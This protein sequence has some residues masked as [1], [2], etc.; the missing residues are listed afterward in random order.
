[1]KHQSG[2]GKGRTWQ[3]GGKPKT[4]Y[5][6]LIFFYNRS[7]LKTFTITYLFSDWL[8]SD[9]TRVL[10]HKTR[11]DAW[12]AKRH[13]FGQELDDGALCERWIRWSAAIQHVH[14][15]VWIM[16]A[17]SGDVHWIYS[18]LAQ[19]QTRAGVLIG[20]SGRGGWDQLWS[21]DVVWTAKQAGPK[22][23]VDKSDR[24]VTGPTGW[25]GWLGL[26]HPWNEWICI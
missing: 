17:S 25:I 9:L 3:E 21:R 6:K 23:L 11:K 26:S 5:S 18:C 7:H 10:Q 4:Y 8:T 19:L 13:A 16:Q 14:C 22:Q 1:M 12:I 2:G 15:E 24:S 20:R